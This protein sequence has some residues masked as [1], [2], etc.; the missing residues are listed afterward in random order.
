MAHRI[1]AGLGGNL[2]L[3]FGNQGARNGGA[4][5][6]NALIKR[7]GAEHRE[8]I[9]ADE[10]LAQVFNINFLNAQHFGFLPCRFQLFAL[11]QIS[12]EGHHFALINILQPF[13]ND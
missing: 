6:I 5:K 10:F 3:P 4:Q 9:I 1:G 12:G 8:D 2:D 13:Q 7:I 11:P